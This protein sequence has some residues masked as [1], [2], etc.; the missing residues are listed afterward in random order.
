MA[1]EDYAISGG[2]EGKQRLDLLADVLRPTTT[3]L[4]RQAGI[5]SGACCLD[6]G[7][8]GGNVTRDLAQLVGPAGRVTGVDFDPTIVE[9]ARR[10]AVAAGTTNVSF[11][12]AD[13]RDF[14]GGPYDAVYARFLLSHVPAPADVL[15]HLIDQLA[16]DGALVVEDVDFSGCFCEPPLAAFDRFVQLYAEAVRAGGGDA[17]LG[18][19][20]P[21]LVR[22]AGLVDA[23]WNVVQPMHAEGPAKDLQ[24]VTMQR[25]APAVLRHRLATQ[26][27]IDE[28]VAAMTVFAQEPD[29]IVSFPRIVQAWGRVPER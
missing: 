29:T 18:R 19:R 23:A 11:E 28:V 4:L 9:L 7:C 15:G 3:N 16:P 2:E 24:T 21:A 25:I 6:A 26:V 14:Q 22:Q 17:Y 27:D 20:L 1:H 13:V 10:D 5:G 12:S 8:G